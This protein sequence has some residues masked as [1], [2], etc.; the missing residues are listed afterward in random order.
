M[1]LL[2]SGAGYF[3]IPLVKSRRYNLRPRKLQS[4]NINK[5]KRKLGGAKKPAKAI[6]AP[7]EALRRDRAERAAEFAKRMDMVSELAL[8]KK[9]N[10]EPENVERRNQKIT[11]TVNILR[12]KMEIP[13]IEIVDHDGN[14]RKSVNAARGRGD[15]NHYRDDGNHVLQVTRAH[16]ITTTIGEM[17]DSLKPEPFLQDKIYMDPK[18]VWKI[19][20]LP[21]DVRQTFEFMETNSPPDAIVFTDVEEFENVEPFD[22]AIVL[23]E[24]DQL[25]YLCVG[26][27]LVKV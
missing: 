20:K 9:S 18:A 7:P 23:N 12:Y 14:P 6:N 22:R 21:H 4:K 3:A 5:H 27:G 19:N 11:L 26:V 16:A 15:L 25:K 24:D 17:E 1:E 8:K 2:T 13:D 10:V